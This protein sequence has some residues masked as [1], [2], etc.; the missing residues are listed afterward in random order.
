MGTS[1][2]RICEKLMPHRTH[3]RQAPTAGL[4]RRGRWRKAEAEEVDAAPAAEEAEAA[5]ETEE[6]E[7]AAEAG[8]TSDGGGERVLRCV[9]PARS[10]NRTA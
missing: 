9:A 8:K 5:G 7:A 1:I 6:G 4:R 10:R 2:H 3:I